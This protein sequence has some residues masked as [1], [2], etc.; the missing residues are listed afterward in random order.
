LLPIAGFGPHVVENVAAQIEASHS[1]SVSPDTDPVD[2]PHAITLDED[3][4]SAADM[5]IV[6]V[7]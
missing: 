5:A 6:D 2:A 3:A 1:T 7:A 4:V